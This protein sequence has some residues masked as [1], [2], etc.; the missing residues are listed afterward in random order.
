MPLKILATGD[1]H[2]GQKVSGL[3]ANAESFSARDTWKRIVEWSIGNQVDV[4]ALTGDIVD[5]DNRYYEA[6]GTLQS[7]FARLKENHIQVYAVA[8]NHDFDVFPQIASSGTLDNVHLLGAGGKW[9]LLA[10]EKDGEKIQ[11]AGWSF[12]VQFITEDPLDSFDL[13]GINKE[14]PCIGLL[15]GEEGNPVS[16]YAPLSLEK[17]MNRPVNT[18]IL[19]H[20]H[21]PQILNNTDP[22]ICYPGSP[23]AFSSKETDSHGPLLITVSGGLISEPERILVS[24]VRFENIKIDISGSESEEKFRGAISIITKMDKKAEQ[25]L[26]DV[27]FLVYDITLTGTHNNIRQLESWSDGLAEDFEHETGFN[28][29]IVVSKVNINAS[30]EI[31]NLEDLARQNSPVGILAQ[32]ILAIRGNTETKFLKQLIS[33]WKEKYNVINNSPVFD[34]LKEIRE[35]D[36]DP[37]KTAREYI[38]KESVRLLGELLK[39]KS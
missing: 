17:F 23:L 8:G 35:T 16:R 25:S 19:G 39:Q 22:Y 33:D 28:T 34:P 32:T 18:W 36:G 3:P 26:R 15:H 7:G 24:P 9:E 31:Q 10:F 4:I 13:T 21:K 30:P 11:F 29:R 2:I 27:R 38:L 1:I 6:V 5:R 12:P 37:E 20:I 14:I